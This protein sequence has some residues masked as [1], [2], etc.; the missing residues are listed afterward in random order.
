[1][2]SPDSSF[3]TDFHA[4]CLKNNFIL[5]PGKSAKLGSVE[6]RA[7]HANHSAKTIGFKLFTPKFILTYSADTAYSKELINDYKNSNILILNLL[8]EKKSKHNLGIEDAVKIIS[9]REIQNKTK[10]QVISARDGLVIDPVS[11]S[12]TMSQKTLNIY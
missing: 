6:V 12:A 9:K 5:E 10:C 4:T 2:V 11:Y 8:Q 7:L 1:M 3:L